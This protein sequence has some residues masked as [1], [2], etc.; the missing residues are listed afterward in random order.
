MHKDEILLQEAYQQINEGMRETLAAAAIIISG[1]ATVAGVNKYTDEYG[2]NSP[3]S[4]Y[5]MSGDTVSVAQHKLAEFLK[6]NSLHDRLSDETLKY[7]QNEIVESCKHIRT[8]EGAKRFF[9]VIK[10]HLTSSENAEDKVSRLEGVFKIAKA[11][12]W[13][14]VDGASVQ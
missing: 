1:L 8:D 10:D 7:I 2:G 12:T 11:G 5:T 4:N 3:R 14:D 13:D 6:N 9:Q